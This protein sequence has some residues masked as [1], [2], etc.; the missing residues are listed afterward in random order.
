[1]AWV[2]LDRAITLAQGHRARPSTVRRWQR[3]RE[4]IRAQIDAAGFDHDRRTY[5]RAFDDRNLDAALALVGPL[6]F[7]RPDSPQALGTLEAIRSELGASGELIF[8][9][10]PGDDGL[11]GGE[12]A[13][14]PCS[15]WVAH[16]L[17]GAGRYE[18][19]AEMLEALTPIG[20]DL[21]LFPEEVDPS[22]GRLLG[23][24]PQALSHSSFVRA[25]LAARDD[26]GSRSRPSAVP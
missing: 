24:F 4:Q 19:A 15:F 20:G 13:F 25:A 22:T 7:D 2:A 16:A 21:G 9:Y 1:M 23:N 5:T 14:L 12:A 11:E 18:A 3:A 8:R 26:H 17:A 10:Q 6:G